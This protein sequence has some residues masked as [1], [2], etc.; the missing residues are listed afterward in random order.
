MFV[1][2]STD[3]RIAS[4]GQAIM[5]AVR[6]EAIVAPLQIRLG[7]Q[8]HRQFGSRFLIDSLYSHVFCPFYSEVQK[9]GRIA[10]FHQGTEIEGINNESFILHIA[11]NVDH[12]IPTTDGLN[13]FHE[14]GIIAAVTPRVTATKLVPK[15]EV[16][17]KDIMQIGS[18]ETH[19]FHRHINSFCLKF[20][21]LQYFNAGDTTGSLE[22][23]C[24]S[25]WML[26]P[27]GPLWNG[28]MQMVHKREHLGHLHANN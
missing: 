12:N 21:S 19:L 24:K 10:A 17:P 18:I 13:T 23:L 27:Q 11:D 20:E 7:V 8:M 6:P 4:I 9:F 26:K 5:Q 15:V 22:I 16:L 28:F 2:K 1:A 25:A 3:L 14:M